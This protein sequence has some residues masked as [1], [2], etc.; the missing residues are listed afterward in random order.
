MHASVLLL[1]L[2]LRVDLLVFFCGALHA[3]ATVQ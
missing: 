1:H 2:H 3:A